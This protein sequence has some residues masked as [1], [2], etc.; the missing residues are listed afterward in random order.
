[1]AASPFGPPG[2]PVGPIN[3]SEVQKGSSRSDGSARISWNPPIETGGLPVLRYVAQM[4]YANTP[5]WHRISGARKQPSGDE[6]ALEVEQ[7]VLVVPTT[8]LVTGLMQSKHYVF[9]VAA[10]NES[11]TGPFLESG[12]FEMPEDEGEWDLFSNIHKFYYVK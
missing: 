5:G 8:T 4:R 12:V 7:G 10:V 2:V 3:I 6:D 11:G 9:R 1:M